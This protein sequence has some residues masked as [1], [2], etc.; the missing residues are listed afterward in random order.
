MAAT[1]YAVRINIQQGSLEVTGP[2]KGWVDAKI[3]ELRPLLEQAGEA[4]SAPDPTPAPSRRKAAKRKPAGDP[5]TQSPE[6]TAPRKPRATSARSGINAELREKLDAPTRKK[7]QEFIATRRA[8]WDGAHTAQAAIIAT[9]LNDELDMPGVDKDDLYT[10]Y[11]VM[12]ERSPANIKSQLTNARQRARYFLG[13]AD[14][15]MALSHVGEN[16]G[17]FDSVDKADAEG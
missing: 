6:S 7:F 3:A 1:D 14:G 15:K 17:R 16:F 12:G 11:T 8:A 13:A 5:A 9:F 10:V 4:R 2:E